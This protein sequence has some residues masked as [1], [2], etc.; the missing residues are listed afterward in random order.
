MK[1]CVIYNSAPHYRKGIFKL[2][3]E[4]YDI[5]WYF[6]KALGDIKS[7]PPSF[8]KHPNYIENRRIIGPLYWQKGIQKLISDS[9][10]NHFLI[11]G[12]LYSLSTWIILIKKK[13]FYPKKRIY[14]W[15]HGWYGKE[16]LSKRIFK[17]IFFNMSDG[18]FLYGNRARDL[19]IQNGFNPKNLHV[20]HNSLDYDQQ[21][22]IRNSLKSSNIYQNHFG[23]TNPVLLFIGRLTKV[24]KLNQLIDAVELLKQ[25]KFFLNIVFVGEG[26]M[27]NALQ[28]QVENLELSNQV[29]FYGKCYEEEKMGI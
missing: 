26:E 20:I 19:M 29:W 25:E 12:E 23:N 7:L 14:L 11:L 13:I 27:K 18:I 28:H 6:D 1:L 9:K 15:S 10:Y 24:K 4:E 17:K 5:D 3:E 8:F 21:L 2:M 22:L 16:S